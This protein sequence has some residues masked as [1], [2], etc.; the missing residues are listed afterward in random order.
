MNEWI[1]KQVDGLTD[2]WTN[3]R[4]DGKADK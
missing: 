1:D 4:M 2:R 3:G